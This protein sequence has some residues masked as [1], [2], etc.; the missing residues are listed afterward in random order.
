MAVRFDLEFKN[1]KGPGSIKG[2]AE[3]LRKGA[4]E[5]VQ[6]VAK[7]LYQLGEE[8]MAESKKTYCPYL[9]G[10]LRSTGYV[11]L[12]KVSD[13]DVTVVMGYGAEY[14]AAVHEI[15]RNYRH[16]KQWKYLETPAK[17]MAPP[18][19]KNVL[20]NAVNKVLRKS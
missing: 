20:N 16:G 9:T 3:A 1:N 7:G 11:E 19:L 2:V 17:E 5:V 18:G 6:E 8:I 14:A 4:E 13:T 10:Y 12:P 15:D